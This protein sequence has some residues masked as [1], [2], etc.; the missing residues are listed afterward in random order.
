[1]PRRPGTTVTAGLVLV[2]V[3]VGLLAVPARFEG[4]A[5][6]RLGEGHGLSTVDAA[7]AVLLALGGTALEVFA[8]RRL[9]RLGLS[10]WALFGLGLAAGTGLGLVVASVLSDFFWWWAVGSAALGAV[11]L[12]LVV[13]ALRPA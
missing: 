7:G 6:L 12:T 2:A 4:P 13:L 8:F 3:G 1:M 11:L 5:L 9:P 10:P